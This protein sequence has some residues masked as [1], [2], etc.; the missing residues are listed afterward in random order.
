MKKQVEH[1]MTTGLLWG[2]MGCHK[3]FKL[4]KR[5]FRVVNRGSIGHRV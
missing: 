1:E 2:F 3:H 5:F 4:V